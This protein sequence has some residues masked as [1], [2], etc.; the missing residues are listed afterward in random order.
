MSRNWLDEHIEGNNIFI[1]K[2]EIVVGAIIKN[3]S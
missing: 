2:A 1:N 3:G